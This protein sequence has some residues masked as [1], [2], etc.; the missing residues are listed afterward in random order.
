LG[1][2]NYSPLISRILWNKAEYFTGDIFTEFIKSWM[3][4]EELERVNSYVWEM[5][6]IMEQWELKNLKETSSWKLFSNMKDEIQFI[7]N[8]ISSLDMND[9]NDTVVCDVKLL[10]KSVVPI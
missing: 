5:L 7:L 3:L 2:K 8:A 4:K 9:I 10:I 1:E 6:V